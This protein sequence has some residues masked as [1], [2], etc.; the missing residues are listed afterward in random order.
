MCI[1]V[2]KKYLVVSVE[3]QFKF[4]QTTCSEINDFKPHSFPIFLFLEIWMRVK[5]G[6]REVVWLR[7][8]V[9]RRWSGR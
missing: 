4:L 2:V 9:A 7:M 1:K 3:K 6:V 8:W 5:K